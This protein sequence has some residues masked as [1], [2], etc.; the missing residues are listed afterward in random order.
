MGG[1]GLPGRGLA[2]RCWVLVVVM[3]A[4]SRSEI[5]NGGAFVRARPS[6]LRRR[7][8][9]HRRAVQSRCKLAETPEAASGPGHYHRAGKQVLAVPLPI[10]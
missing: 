5:E 8:A 6:G 10:A 4:S 3:P 9:G 1:Q 2:G 7:W